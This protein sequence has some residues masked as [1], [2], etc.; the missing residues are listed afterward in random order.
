MNMIWAVMAAMGCPADWVGGSSACEDRRGHLY[1]RSLSPTS[2]TGNN[3]SLTEPATMKNYGL[4]NEAIRMSVDTVAL[5][6]SQ[7]GGQKVGRNGIWEFASLN[8]TLQGLVGLH[9]PAV[10]L[11]DLGGRGYGDA[12]FIQTLRDT[13]NIPSLSYGYTAGALYRK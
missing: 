11:S 1:D 9:Q 7:S 3:Y 8:Y 12:S 10:N 2:T 5:G 4:D 6:D 13:N